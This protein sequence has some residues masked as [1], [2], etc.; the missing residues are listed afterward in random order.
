MTRTVALRTSFFFVTLTVLFGMVGIGSHAPIAEALFLI[1]G[2]LCAL[3][4]LFAFAAPRQAAV[5]VRV[6]P[7]RH[8]SL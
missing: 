7:T 3:M 1:G 5:P 4:V 6:R 2:S 8:R